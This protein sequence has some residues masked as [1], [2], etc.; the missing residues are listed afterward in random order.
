VVDSRKWRRRICVH[1]A[2]T[3]HCQSTGDVSILGA[4][5]NPVVLRGLMAT[6]GYWKGLLFED[7]DNASDVYVVDHAEIRDA[8]GGEFNSNGDLGGIIPWTDTSL[9]VTNTLF[10]NL[11][12]TCAINSRYFDPDVDTYV[13]TGSSTDGTSTLVC[14]PDAI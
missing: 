1:T 10:A 5:G 6:P 7:A 12:A 14:D 4:A 9:S 2:S 13:T 11:A 3:S 8:G